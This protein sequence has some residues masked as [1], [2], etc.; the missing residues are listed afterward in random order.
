MTRKKKPKK[1]D[2]LIGKPIK[3]DDPFTRAWNAASPIPDDQGQYDGISPERK[4]AEQLKIFNKGMN[5]MSEKVTD[6]YKS[7]AIESTD[8]DK[9]QQLSPHAQYGYIRQ[10]VRDNPELLSDPE[11]ASRL[12][13]EFRKMMIIDSHINKK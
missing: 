5:D 12:S 11:F 3:P 6:Y 10:K 13:P 7:K 9:L 4:K 8:I 2:L 1:Y